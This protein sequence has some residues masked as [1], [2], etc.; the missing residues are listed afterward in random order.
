MGMKF[1][2][3][4]LTPV[5][6]GIVLEAVDLPLVVWIVRRNTSNLKKVKQVRESLL[7]SFP[8]IKTLPDH[9][10]F[11]VDKRPDFLIAWAVVSL[12]VR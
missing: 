12:L 3:T 8:E 2:T 6:E 10:G 1:P 4:K 11:L 9:P 5:E 7:L